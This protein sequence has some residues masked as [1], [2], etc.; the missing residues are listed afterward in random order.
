LGDLRTA[1]VGELWVVSFGGV[2][3]LGASECEPS[4][5]AR[6]SSG[7]GS[8]SCCGTSSGPAVGR[9]MSSRRS[10]AGGGPG[11]IGSIRSDLADQQVEAVRSSWGDFGAT[12]VPDG[13]QLRHQA[14]GSMRASTT[15]L[16]A[17]ATVSIERGDPQSPVY[18]IECRRATGGEAWAVYR[19]FDDVRL[20]SCCLLLLPACFLR[21]RLSTLLP[22]CVQSCPARSQR[23]WFVPRSFA[24]CER[25]FWAKFPLY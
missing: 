21:A 18:T 20:P 8:G 17:T 24:F 25:I 11:S 13:V 12:I 22:A 10:R 23:A 1:R 9:M 4:P 16:R 14:G 19:Q 6:C 3:R 2:K 15:D 5:G 7:S